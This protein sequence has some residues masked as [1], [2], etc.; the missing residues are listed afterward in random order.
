MKEITEQFIPQ[1]N[2]FSERLKEMR[3]AHAE[4][5]VTLGGMQ[6]ELQQNQKIMIAGLRLEAEGN[7]IAEATIPRQTIEQFMADCATF[8]GEVKKLRTIFQQH[9]DDANIALGGISGLWGGYIENIGVQYMLNSLR[10]DY[11]VHTWYQKFKRYWH[12]SRNVEIDLLALS[13]T[14]AY[15][16]EVKNQLKPEGFAQMLTIIDKMEEHLPEYNH[17]IKQPVMMCMHVDEHIVNTAVTGG[18]W[19][20]RYKGFDRNKPQNSFEWVRKDGV[21]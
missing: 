6:K 16:I 11:G 2:E 7:P 17:L 9:I 8:E 3:S 18:I 10:K 15:I 19:I 4:H 12:K 21:V 20:L 14:H 13:D 5:I 1:L